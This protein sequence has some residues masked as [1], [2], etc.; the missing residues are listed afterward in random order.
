MGGGSRHS[1]VWGTLLAI[2]RIDLVVFGRG[3][4]DDQRIS[5]LDVTLVIVQHTNCQYGVLGRYILQ[6]ADWLRF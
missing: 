6:A 5:A 4:G 2:A 1:I 3:M